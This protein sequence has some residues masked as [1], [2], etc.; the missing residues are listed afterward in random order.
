[1]TL[2]VSKYVWSDIKQLGCKSD[3]TKEDVT[4]P[5][6]TSS[7]LD[8]AGCAA[9]FLLLRQRGVIHLSHDLCEQLVHHG[10]ALSRGLDEGAAPLL[11]QSPAVCPGDLALGLQV[12]FVPNQDQR[13][14]L[15]ALHSHYLVPHR[16][17]VLKD[18]EGKCSF[19]GLS[20]TFNF[21]SENKLCKSEEQ[22]KKVHIHSYWFPFPSTLCKELLQRIYFADLWWLKLWLILLDLLSS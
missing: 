13:H 12:D 15:E 8:H 21:Q 19:S 9:L 6:R 14:L 17:D 1:M 3:F 4:G 10:L 11:S 2:T 22:S 20:I 7:S 18:E 5:A 16:S